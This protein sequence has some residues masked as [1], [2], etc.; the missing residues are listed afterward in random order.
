M[1]VTGRP[2]KL[3]GLTAFLRDSGLPVV[4]LSFAQLRSIA[5]LAASAEKHSAW[6]ANS[7]TG[8]PH[9][10][11]WLDAGY[12][13]HPDFQNRTVRFVRGGKTHRRPN[14]EIEQRRSA[15]PRPGTPR[16]GRAVDHPFSLPSRAADGPIGGFTLGGPVA[17]VG[18]NFPAPPLPKGRAR[19][20][21]GYGPFARLVMPPLPDGPGLYLWVLDHQVVYVGQTRTPLRQRLGPNGYS[22]ISGYNTLAP[23][24]GKRNG[25]QQTNCRINSLA[26]AALLAGGSLAIWYRITPAI[27]AAEAE[28]LWMRRFGIPPWNRRI[29]S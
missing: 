11:A 12:A 26:N 18:L 1:A 10:A 16:A 3:D 28:R 21:Y 23:E 24:T 14:H 9:S 8:R 6:W 17:H 15:A 2:R 13:A 25:G 19:H 5:E 20:Q 27:E 29:E 7:R 4:E 22:T